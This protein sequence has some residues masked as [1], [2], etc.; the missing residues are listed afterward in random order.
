MAVALSEKI[1]VGVICGNEISE[2]N[3]RKCITCF[4]ALEAAM[5]SPENGQVAISSRDLAS[6]KNG[7]FWEPTHKK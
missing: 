5:Y 6:E 4:E 1:M 3:C 7:A 2:A